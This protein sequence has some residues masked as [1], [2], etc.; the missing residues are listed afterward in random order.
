[1]WSPTVFTQRNFVAD[2][3][4]AKCD[5]FTEIGR[6]AFLRCHLGD[7]GATYD[8]HLRLIRKRVYLHRL[9]VSVNWTFFARCYGWGVRANIGWKS[10]ISLQR[11][12]VNPKFQLEGVSPTNHSL[13]QKTRLNHLSYGIKI[14]TDFS[15]FL[16]QFTRLT[17]RQRDRETDGQLSRH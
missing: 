2:L 5:F 15:S 16:S 8:D 12:P 10:V 17:D 1:M 14:W 3:L 11:G 9:P 7:L 6:L 13:S 4:Q